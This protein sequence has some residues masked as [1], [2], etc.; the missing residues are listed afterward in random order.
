MSAY[1]DVYQGPP[2][3]GAR[4]WPAGGIPSKGQ[5]LGAGERTATQPPV[6]FMV[7]E[8]TPEGRAAGVVPWS[9]RLGNVLAAKAATC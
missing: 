3:G 8:P 7:H 2:D 5:R 1:S 4:L 6:G 9:R